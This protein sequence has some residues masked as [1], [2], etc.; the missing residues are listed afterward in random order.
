MHNLETE[1]LT[2]PD[3]GLFRT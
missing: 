3:Y 2:I 1:Y